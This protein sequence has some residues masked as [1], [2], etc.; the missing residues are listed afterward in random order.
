MATLRVDKLLELTHSFVSDHIG[1]KF[2]EPVTFDLGRVFSECEPSQPIIY[3][4]SGPN[5]ASADIRK[6]ATERSSSLVLFSMGGDDEILMQDI[7]LQS[8]ENGEKWVLLE[9]FESAINIRSTLKHHVRID[10]EFHKGY[11]LWIITAPTQKVILKNSSKFIMNN[12]MDLMN[13][14]SRRQN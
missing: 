3:L 1:Y 11:R 14:S 2:V 7:L 10:Q 9:N 13:F 12:L 4:T 5:E 6:F 8:M